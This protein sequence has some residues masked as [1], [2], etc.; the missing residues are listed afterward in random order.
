M[1]ELSDIAAAVFAAALKVLALSDT[2]LS[3]KPLL[4]AKRLKQRM[5]ASEDGRLCL[6]FHEA[7][8]RRCHCFS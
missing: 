6:D 7:L 5:K 4:A 1:V 2:I 8:L 3:G